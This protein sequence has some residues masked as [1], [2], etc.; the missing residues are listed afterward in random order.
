MLS[1]LTDSIKYLF[2]RPSLRIRIFEEKES[3]PVGGLRFE[4]ENVGNRPTSLRPE[5]I[6]T[7]WVLERRELRKKKAAYAVRE[8]DRELPPFKAR[9]LSASARDLHPNYGFSWFRSYLFRT[10]TGHWTR[11]HVRH[12]LLD[13]LSPLRFWWEMI[14]FRTTGRLDAGATSMSIDRMIDDQRA[15]G[16]H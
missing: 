8:S 4:I 9:V 14:R 2:G 15:R 11:A 3:E 16:P 10:T 1:L 13:P 6:V 5:I 7:Y 12:A